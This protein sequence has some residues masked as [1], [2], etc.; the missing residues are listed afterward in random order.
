[1]MICLIFVCILQAGNVLCGLSTFF[2]FDGAAE[3]NWWDDLLLSYF[4]LQ[5][6]IFFL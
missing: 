6:G 3:T 2:C 5:L 4:L 1:M